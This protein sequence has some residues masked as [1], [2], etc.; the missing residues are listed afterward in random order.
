MQY[1]FQYAE[2]KC[3]AAGD[4]SPE[5][6]GMLLVKSRVLTSMLWFLLKVV[7]S[8]LTHLRSVFEMASL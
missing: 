1:E 5:Q 8:R 2:G 6:T 3:F 7:E 4:S